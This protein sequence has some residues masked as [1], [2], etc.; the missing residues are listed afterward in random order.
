MSW[1]KCIPFDCTS[2][3]IL[4]KRYFL[5]ITY[6]R[7]EDNASAILQFEEIKSNNPDN[8]EVDLILKNLRDGNDP[9]EGAAPPID[10]EPEARENPPI[11]ESLEVDDSR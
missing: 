4:W 5:G 7:L 10:D 11:D 9:F 6:N 3:K 8:E 2:G 1:E